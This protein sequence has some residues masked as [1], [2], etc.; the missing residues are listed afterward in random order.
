MDAMK[1]RRSLTRATAL[2]SVGLAGLLT[3][4]ACSS[5]VSSTGGQSAA[6]TQSQ[7]AVQTTPPDTGAATAPAGP[8]P[9]GTA[10]AS[11]PT[12]P[13]PTLTVGTPG[14]PPVISSLLPYIADKE[15]FYKAFGVDVTVKNFQ[16][17]T[18]ATR[19]LSAGQIDVSIVPPAQ[20]IQL[21]AKGIN[22]VGIMGQEK[23]DWVIASSDPSINSCQKL[24]GQSLGVDAIGGIRYIALAQMLKTCGL[25]IKDVHPLVFSGNANPQAMIAGQLKVSVLHLNEKIDVEQHSGKQLT[26]TMSMATAVPN[27]MYEIYGVQK[28]RLPQL[29]DAL[30]RF[31]AAQIA[32]L[33]WMF[34]P[35]N[36][37]KVAQLGT[38][39]GDS[40]ATMKAAMEQY[41][42]VGFWTL[43]GP[44]MPEANIAQM[45]KGQ[46][47]AGNVQAGKAP[48]AADLIDTS[49][50]ADAQKL[51]Q[52]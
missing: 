27:T 13:F 31:D 24:K 51:V 11:A 9:S 39:V 50:Y 49:I 52:S 4:A 45:I 43:D 40:E 14:I 7:A 8:A 42:Q 22:L 6:P 25:T 18:D 35:A 30:V 19:A 3:L 26:T 15:G 36:A 34:D 10:P 41:K 44:G 28:S 38:V 33:N 2:A 5:S 29:R 47:A 1:I 20:Q 16:T 12:Q 48:N 46:V 32:T 17:G 23:P 21:A 37:D